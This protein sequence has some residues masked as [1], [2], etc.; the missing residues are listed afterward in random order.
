M[1][2][3]WV[4]LS[5]AF[6]SVVIISAL[7]LLALIV[8]YPEFHRRHTQRPI[9]MTATQEAWI[10]GEQ[11]I[12]TQLQDHFEAG[13]SLADAVIL[14]ADFDSNQLRDRSGIVLLLRSPINQLMYGRL[15]PT[16]E[17]EQIIFAGGILEYTVTPPDGGAGRRRGTVSPQNLFL[18][19]GA[20]GTILGLATAILMSRWLVAPLSRLAKTVRRAGGR[21]FSLRVK[22]EGSVEIQDVAHA[23]NEM[24]SQLQE[25]EQLRNNLI[26][27][28]AHELRTPLT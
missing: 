13:G 9:P 22:P 15:S 5:L 11:G 18:F 7:M 16:T 1:Q 2:R 25:S 27:D 17:Y 21:D 26:A 12:A 14:V 28:V 20:V 23:F 10:Y 8:I 4:Q 24:S 6:C 3:L 19:L